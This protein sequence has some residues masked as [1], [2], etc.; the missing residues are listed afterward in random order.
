MPGH[1]QYV[2]NVTPWISDTARRTLA[3]L[4]G[5]FLDLTG[6]FRDMEGQMFTDYA[7]LTPRANERL[8][9]VVADSILPLIASRSASSGVGARAESAEAR[10]P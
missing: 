4:G 1:D 7:H 6:I 9:R 3:P 10:R 8:A 5:H 2:R